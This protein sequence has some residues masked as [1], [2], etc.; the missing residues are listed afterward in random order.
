[1]D[2]FK[3]KLKEK[4][5][6]YSNDQYLDGYIKKEFFTSDGDADIYIN[7]EDKYELFDSWTIGGQIDLEKDVYEFIEE[8]TS[9]LGNHI[10]INL[11][12]VGYEFTSHEQGVIRHILKEH[13]AIELYKAQKEYT[14]YKNKI[15][16][17]I[18]IGF[19]SFGLY[20]FL[21]FVERFNYLVEVF[22]F[23]FSFALWEAMDCAI[24]S[25][26]EA[27]EKREAITQN[28]LMNVSFD[29]EKDIKKQKITD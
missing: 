8:K 4:I 9:M 21:F 23:L 16:C 7:I 17:L 20:S 5:K 24:Y 2:T 1:M 18:L 28:L 14:N 6:K 15:L 22:G 12:I 11:H 25:F 3:K 29:N 27:K 13:Y 10:P 19:A 26:S